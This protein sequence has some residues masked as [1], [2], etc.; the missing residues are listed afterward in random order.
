[1]YNEVEKACCLAVK[2]TVEIC[3]HT[4]CIYVYI[5][6]TDYY[7]HNTLIGFSSYIAINYYITKILRIHINK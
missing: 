6:L 3:I 5:N 4:S 2:I 7:F 1:M